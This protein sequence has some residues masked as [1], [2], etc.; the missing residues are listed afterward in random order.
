M[1]GKKLRILLLTAVACLNLR[2]TASQVNAHAEQDTSSA[3][4]GFESLGGNWVVGGIYYSDRIVDI[5]DNEQ[6]MAIYDTVFLNFYEDGTFLYTNMYNDRGQYTLQT[7]GTF[8]LKT[9]TVFLYDITSKGIVEKEVEDASK[10]TYIVNLLDKNTLQ[11]GVLDPMTG[12]EKAGS[13]PLIFEREGVES[14]FISENKVSLNKSNSGTSTGKTDESTAVSPGM[15]NALQSAKDYLDAIP[16]SRK[17]LIEQ[18]EYEGYSR[19]EAVYAVEHCGADWNKQACDMAKDYLEV[20]S[21]SRS[22][23]IEQLEFEGFTHSQAVYGVDQ[24]YR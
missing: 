1:R 4:V 13:D 16:F 14:S 8:F 2:A 17:G 22:S 19:S 24:A 7:N 20:M 18:L 5:S 23:L 3:A 21:F 15:R 10:I 11:L 6:L 12:R 9:E